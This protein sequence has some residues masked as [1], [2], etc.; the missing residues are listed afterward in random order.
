[1]CDSARQVLG[2]L[3]AMSLK[4]VEAARQAVCRGEKDN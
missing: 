1:M 3:K 4:V 2:F